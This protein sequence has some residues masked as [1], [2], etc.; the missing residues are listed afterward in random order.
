MSIG[1]K[2][3]FAEDSSFHLK[4]PNS[5]DIWIQKLVISQKIWANYPMKMKAENHRKGQQLFFS[6]HILYPSGL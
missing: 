4:D 6:V 5:P 3:R 2:T 1:Q